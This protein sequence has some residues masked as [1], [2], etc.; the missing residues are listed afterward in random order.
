MTCHFIHKDFL[1]ILRY[2]TTLVRRGRFEW[3]VGVCG[4]EGAVFGKVADDVSVV[5][6]AGDV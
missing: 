3:V 6:V 1:A 2:L 5:V 4:G